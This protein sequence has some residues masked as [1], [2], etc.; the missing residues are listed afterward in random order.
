MCLGSNGLNLTN[1][2]TKNPRRRPYFTNDGRSPKRENRRRKKTK[3]VKSHRHTKKCDTETKPAVHHR[4]RRQKHRR[5]RR[6]ITKERCISGNR[7][8]SVKPKAGWKM[9]ETNRQYKQKLRPISISMKD[10][11]EGTEKREKFFCLKFI[12][13]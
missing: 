3:P 11:G 13:L 1:Y 9:P 10:R 8:R 7:N 12:I 4:K 2:K 5:Q 6:E